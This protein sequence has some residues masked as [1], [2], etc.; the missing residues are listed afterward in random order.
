MSD[1]IEANVPQAERERASEVLVRILNG[2]LFELAQTHAA[3][4]PA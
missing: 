2:A 4:A 3:N 1:F